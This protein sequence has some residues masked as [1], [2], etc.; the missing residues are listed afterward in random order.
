MH[1]QRPLDS[2][3]PGTRSS[4][5]LGFRRAAAAA[6]AA[7]VTADQLPFEMRD[8]G[9]VGSALEGPVDESA[10]GQPARKTTRHQSSRISGARRRHH[11]VRG[12]S[13]S[14]TTRLGW[15][16]DGAGRPRLYATD[17]ERQAAYR[18]RRRSVTSS[19]VENQVGKPPEGGAPDNT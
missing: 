12:C 14:G 15:S 11:G 4:R 17:A 19:V 1:H 18:A 3:T 8:R 13:R 9:D 7:A 10:D 6:S 2:V 5:L 16:Q